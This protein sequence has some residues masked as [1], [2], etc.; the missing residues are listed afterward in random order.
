MSDCACPKVSRW[1][2]ILALVVFLS[3]PSASVAHADLPPLS[4]T[5]NPVLRYRTRVEAYPVRA[6]IEQLGLLGL[7]FA[8]YMFNSGSNSVDWQF[9]Y[10]WDSFQ[11]KLDGSGYA[12]DTNHFD[13]NFLSHP[14]SGSLYYL[15]ARGNRL[16]PLV[17][18]VYSALSSFMWELVGEFREQVS[19]NDLWVT[20]VSGFVFGE[21]TLQLGGFFD[22]S[23]RSL[24]NVLLGTLLAPTK[25][26]HDAMDGVHPRRDGPC[27]ARGLSLLGAH[28]FRMSADLAATK[29]LEGSAYVALRLRLHTRIFA[30]DSYG[31]PGHGRQDF[32]LANV[33]ELWLRGSF[34]HVPLDFELGS[35]L[36][37]FGIHSRDLEAAPSGGRPVG[38]EVTLGLWVGLQYFTHRYGGGDQPFDRFFA[39][40]APGFGLQYRIHTA[41]LTWELELYV[42]ATFAGADAFALPNYVRSESTKLLTSVA[43]AEGY[44]YAV[45]LTAVPR[46]RVQ[47]RGFELGAELHAI[48]VTGVRW[49]DRNHL[50]GTHSHV[51]ISEALRRGALWLAVQPGDTPFRVNLTLTLLQRWGALGNAARS[52]TELSLA[53]GVGA[54][55]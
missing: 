40:Q 25:A 18:L 12:F 50:N 34:T 52:N 3:L 44:N 13:T 45:G 19:I 48:E 30:L 27:D 28:E 20:P 36:L 51:P 39:L 21:T 42:G 23:C 22:R 38:D 35:S 24:G 8:Q 4:L 41:M 55:L 10:D 26:V 43:R 14:S 9:T 47:A 15:T 33:S 37:L 31:R 1:A 54:V 46:A 53:A 11:K 32:T 29:L 7:G 16:T 17:S 2:P 49:R 6:A 5:E